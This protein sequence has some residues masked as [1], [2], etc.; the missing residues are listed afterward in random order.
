MLHQHLVHLK[1][2]SSQFKFIVRG[3]RF[4]CHSL[5]TPREHQLSALRTKGFAINGNADDG[6]LIA[7]SKYSSSRFSQDCPNWFPNSSLLTSAFC[8]VV[9][10]RRLR[11]TPRSSSFRRFYSSFVVSRAIHQGRAVFLVALFSRG[12]SVTC[13]PLAWCCGESHS[14][15]MSI[16]HVCPL[17]EPL[18][19]LV[20]WGLKSSS[21]PGV[22]E[23]SISRRTSASLLGAE[24]LL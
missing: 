11:N 12:L 9:Q 24:L 16:S 23:A 2:L 10:C 4:Q 15:R 14:L 21:V 19:T 1:T 17:V 13:F 7:S 3:Q 18:F 6:A 20:F 5:K 8:W 22:V